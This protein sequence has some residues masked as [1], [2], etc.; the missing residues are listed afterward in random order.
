MSAKRK[1]KDALS[2]VEDALRALQRASATVPNEPNISR[3]I[4][5]LRDAETLLQRA[6]RE[7]S[8]LESQ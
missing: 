8:R 1:V 3:A 5:E 4:R 7:V 2:A 6:A